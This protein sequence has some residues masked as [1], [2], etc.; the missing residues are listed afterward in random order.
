VFVGLVPPPGT[1]CGSP[2]SIASPMDMQRSVFHLFDNLDAK[3]GRATRE[4]S[5]GQEPL[6]ESPWL[7]STAGARARA[8]P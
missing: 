6:E 8:R 3:A 5:Q 4:T 1:D 7:V 2:D